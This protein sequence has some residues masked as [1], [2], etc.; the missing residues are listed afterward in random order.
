MRAA[1]SADDVAAFARLQTFMRE[2]RLKRGLSQR[3]L[4]D[5][6]GLPH[7]TIAGLEADRGKSRIP[8]IPTLKK[9]AD[10]LGVNLI[11]L[12]SVLAGLPP[13]QIQVFDKLMDLASLFA[14]ASDE[15]RLEFITKLKGIAQLQ[16]IQQADGIT[17]GP[18]QPFAK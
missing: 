3:A 13:G 8:E 17:T 5:A 18:G 4:A 7:A 6:S 11:V 1:R 15:D 10:G 12:Q 16:L 9:L 14:D 2:A